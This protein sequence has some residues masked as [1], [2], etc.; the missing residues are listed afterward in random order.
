MPR[1]PQPVTLNVRSPEVHRAARLL[2]RLRGTSITQAV[3]HALHEELRR[4]KR[5][6]KPLDELARMEEIARRVAALP[7]RDK[8]TDEEILGYGRG[9]FPNGH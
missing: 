9:G 8:R 4:E 1:K 2:A 6:A 5:R 3:R 7:L